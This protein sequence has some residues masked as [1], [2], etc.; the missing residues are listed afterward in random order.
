MVFCEICNSFLIS[1]S[2]A[3]N[4]NPEEQN[5]DKPSPFKNLEYLEC[6]DNHG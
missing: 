2:P 4:R 3:A 5:D 1:I 6:W